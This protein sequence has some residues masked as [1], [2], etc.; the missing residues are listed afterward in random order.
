[1]KLYIVGEGRNTAFYLIAET[2]ECLA[3]HFCSH[4]GFAKS[5]L[6]DGRPERQKDYKEKFG[7][8]EVLYLGDDDMT[9]KR[10]RELNEEW[11]EKNKPAE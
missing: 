10:I 2:G 8:Y 7:D 1:M 11:F 6:H 9:L 5:D 3:S 4:I